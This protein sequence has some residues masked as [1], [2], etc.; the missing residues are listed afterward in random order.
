LNPAPLAL[1]SL[2]PARSEGGSMNS[3]FVTR[4][5][6]NKLSGRGNRTIGVVRALALLGEV[7][8]EYVEQN[9][10]EPDS[11]LV[12]NPA[13]RLRRI[14]TTVGLKRARLQRKAHGRGMPRYL[15]NGL[16]GELMAALVEAD[17][18][19]YD[20]IVADGPTAAAALLCQKQLE[21]FY[22]AHNFET[23]MHAG[24][25]GWTERDAGELAEYERRLFELARESWLPSERD[26]SGAAKLAPGTR[27][28]LVHNVVDV[29]SI[30]P[31]R[32]P[33]SHR[34][35]FVADYSYQP[36]RHSARFLINEVMPRV[37]EQRKEARLML[38]GRGLAQTG[39][40][41]PRIELHGFVE[42]LPGVYSEAGCALVPLLESGGSPF[43]LIEA[44]AYGLPVV[45]TPL[46]A[47]GVDGLESGVNYI[48]GEG[49]EGFAR[50]VVEALDRHGR[51]V[52]AAARELAESRYSIEALAER[53][54]S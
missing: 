3:L 8:V 2:V 24:A 5:T 23:A 46:A 50:A 26:L 34:A 43:K 25:E 38:V 35:L 16:S 36:N 40:L 33:K 1:A 29:A 42:D 27:L 19:R 54:A 21:I 41:D 10:V 45:A 13:I 9:G 44:L 14:T 49:A 30:T 11:T 22:N 32:M 4:H 48:E 53:L 51:T 20:R 52:G 17:R 47:G 31:V 18:E 15:A 12:Q 6:P 37:W 39:N 7:D 28:R